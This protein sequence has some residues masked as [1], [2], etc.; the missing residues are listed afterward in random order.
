[1]TGYLMDFHILE[2]HARGETTKVSH[3]KIRDRCVMVD[4]REKVQDGFKV[5]SQQLQ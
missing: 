4:L 2:Y 1:M 5:K 3:L